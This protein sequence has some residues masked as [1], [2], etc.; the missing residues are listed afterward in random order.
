MQCIILNWMIL[1]QMAKLEWG[2]RIKWLVVVSANFLIDDC[3]T[4][5]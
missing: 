5:M 2:L 3:D 1:G 4:V